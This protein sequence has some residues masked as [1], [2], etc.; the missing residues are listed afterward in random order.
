MA[1]DNGVWS[2]T[3][4]L[5]P[6]TYEYLF[7]KNVWQ[8]NGGA[9][10]GSNCDFY[11]CDEY[12]NYGLIVSN[13]SAPIELDTYCWGTCLDCG[14]EPLTY[15]V[16]FRVDMNNVTAPFTTPE[17]NGTFNNWCGGCAPMSDINNDGIW[18]LT[19]A[20]QPGNYEY[21]FAYD[22]WAGEE[23]L[24]EGSSCT[25]TNFGFTNRF[26]S[27]AD[28][29]V[30]PIVCWADCNA[31][32][33]VIPT[34]DVT[35]SVDMNNV[36]ENFTT[37]ELNGTFNGW[38]GSC[39]PLSDINS[40]G[41]WEVTIALQSGFY[42]YKFSYDTW[43]GQETLT[44]GDPCTLTS[45]IFTNRTL[46]VTQNTFLPTVCWESCSACAGNVEV[47]FR[48]DMSNEIVSTEGVHLAGSFQN[49]DPSGTQMDHLGFGIYEATLSIAANTFH[50]YKFVNGN[51]WNE[52]ESV[53]GACASGMNRFLTTSEQD[54]NLGIVC[55]SSCELCAGCT[56][57]LS[58]EFNPYA[59]SDDGS[60]QTSLIF[61]CT[62]P[63]ATNFNPG[64][65]E[66]DGSCIFEAGSD[67]PADLNTD[68]II[69]LADLL[70]FIAA[71]GSTC[72]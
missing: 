22:S 13:G 48:V 44:P 28:N 20:L 51:D 72:P 4:D 57:P 63:D 64:A 46:T 52:D 37:P 36:V 16:T 24:N 65:N 71:Y 12:A 2:I 38:C 15:D 19:I 25:V 34:Y 31:C 56:D 68:G 6:G 47:R 66:E 41:I 45:G 42:E 10:L 60:C 26:L 59:G 67:C 14:A 49:W 33:L 50:E 9:P 58:L 69:G 54:L 32:E 39:I 3:V 23:T 30:L 5:E 29:T 8:E 70:G 7:T 43:L 62:Y 21:K 35:F 55:F 1:E 40:D 11:P 53:P 17:V 27:V 18:E 61:G